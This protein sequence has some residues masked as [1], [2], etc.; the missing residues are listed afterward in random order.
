MTARDLIY[1]IQSDISVCVDVVTGTYVDS[2]PVGG[3]AFIDKLKTGLLFTESIPVAWGN[4]VVD[5][6]GSAQVI[7][8][9]LAP[10]TEEYKIDWRGQGYDIAI[11]GIQNKG[12]G[13]E[14][15]TTF[16]N[17]L[18][19]YSGI[20]NGAPRSTNSFLFSFGSS[21][22]IWDKEM[23]DPLLL[24]GDVASSDN[25]D[26]SATSSTLAQ[27]TG[28]IDIDI[29]RSSLSAAS[30]PIVIDFSQLLTDLDITVEG[31]VETVHDNFFFENVST[32][33]VN[34]STTMDLTVEIQDNTSSTQTVTITSS[35]SM[36][37]VDFIFRGFDQG[38]VRFTWATAFS[39]APTA[40]SLAKLGTEDN[41]VLEW[42][43]MGGVTEITFTIS[44]F[45][46]PFELNVDEGGRA[47]LENGAKIWPLKI[48]ERKESAVIGAFTETP[49][50]SP[51]G[52]GEGNYTWSDVSFD[53]LSLANTFDTSSGNLVMSVDGN[54][55]TYQ[56]DLTGLTIIINEA[57]VDPAGVESKIQFAPLMIG[58]AENTSP[59]GLSRGVYYVAFTGLT[60]ARYDGGVI[61]EA[62]SL[63]NLIDNEANDILSWL[64][65][66]D[67]GQAIPGVSN[68]CLVSATTETGV[69]T[70]D[71]GTAST[72][73]GIVNKLAEIA[74]ITVNSIDS[75]LAAWP[76]A[77]YYADQVTFRQALDQVLA[78]LDAFAK[79]VDGELVVERRVL[80][81]E[82]YDRE[83]SQRINVIDNKIDIGLALPNYH[84]LVVG[85]NKNWT[86]QPQTNAYKND[87]KNRSINEDSIKYS[88][89]PT[90]SVRSG[91]LV[92]ILGTCLKSS[93]AAIAQFP[94]LDREKLEH[95]PV[96]FT[97]DNRQGDVAN[98]IAVNIIS[99]LLSTGMYTPQKKMLITDKKTTFIEGVFY[100]K[101]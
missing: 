99:P 95:L 26:F 65:E 35:V 57:Y 69:F 63:L 101:L 17:R 47:H 78:P 98:N 24:E 87:F 25:I 32:T 96:K 68:T 8:T 86:V 88:D 58:Q 12:M 46:A 56:N 100:V 21:H 19:F 45:A 59:L 83:I 36:E 66:P 7:N 60:E 34:S 6:L 27:S 44:N 5:V 31:G 71:Y 91:S 64:I 16:E 97:I 40:E 72:V 77:W 67:G 90:N 20:M 54:R 92:K 76:A 11:C 43:D 61:P 51:S 81:T 3:G 33:E 48:T 23:L 55:V 9:D 49:S 18:P 82:T 89:Y 80:Y 15:V 30:T 39:P 84:K 1:N 62:T 13:N 37:A 41:T 10:L 70:A 42:V 14:I 85:Y 38:P 2:E 29:E 74:G 52:G 50:S 22:P 79:I 28:D 75:T 73:G 93:A 94:I 4:S 53:T